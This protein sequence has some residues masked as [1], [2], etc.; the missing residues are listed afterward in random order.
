[1]KHLADEF[2]LWRLIRVLLF[3]LHDEAK[4]AVLERRIGRSNNDGIPVGR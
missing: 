3:K 1:M 4:R 2:D